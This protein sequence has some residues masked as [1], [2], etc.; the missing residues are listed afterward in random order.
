MVSRDVFIYFIYV[1]LNLGDNDCMDWSDEQ[2]FNF[3]HWCFYEVTTIDCDEHLCQDETWSC[4]DGQCI[5]WQDRLIFQDMLTIALPCYNEREANYMCELHPLR[6]SW[7]LPDGLCSFSEAHFDDPELSLNNIA[8]SND[9]KCLYLIRC[10]LPDGY[11]LDC[12]CNH[13]FVLFR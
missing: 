10:A 2:Q 8:L 6:L 3:G 7:T 9:E 1:D 12:P 5:M 4:G 13:L 11:E